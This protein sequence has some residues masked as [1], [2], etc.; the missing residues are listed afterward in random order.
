M[1]YTEFQEDEDFSIF[2][3][4]SKSKYDLKTRVN[5]NFIMLSGSKTTILMG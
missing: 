5:N 1:I 4:S 2:Y 3:L